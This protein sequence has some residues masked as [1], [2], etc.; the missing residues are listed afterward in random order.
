MARDW[1]RTSLGQVAEWS[2]GTTPSKAHREYWS[3]DIPWVSPKDMK[4]FELHDTQDHISKR[5]VDDGA[6]LVPS[7][8]VFI[9]VRGMILA[10]T[11]PVCIA[12]RAMSFLQPGHQST[13][14]A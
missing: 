3:G 7:D 1:S 5:A 12:Q 13:G 10:H 4:R 14:Y 9:V 11:F 8:T 6:K 2:S